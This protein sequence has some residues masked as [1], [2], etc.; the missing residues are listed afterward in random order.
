MDTDQRG[1][2]AIFDEAAEI[3][4]REARSAYLDHAC[5]ADPEL[6]R[7]VELLLRAY[8]EA[9]S[10]MERPAIEVAIGQAPNPPDS[11]LGHAPR[12]IAEGPGTWIGLFK[13]ISQIGE[14]GMGVV[15]MAEQE[16]P[17]RR[18]VALKIIKPGM[19]SA[20]V[21]A[22][23]EAERQALAMMDHPNIARVLDAGTTDSGRPYFVMEL[24]HGVPITRYCD[25][26]HLTPRERLDL[27]LPVCQAIQHAHQKGIIHRDIKPSNVLVTLYDGKPVPKVIDFGV[28][29][30]V[31]QSITERTV[32]TQHGSVVGTLEYMSPEQ[33]EVSPLGVDT[34]SDIYALGVLLY[35]LLTGS[36]PLE[37]ATLREAGYNEI[38]RRIKE[39]EPPRPST[40]LS[41]SRER[42]ASISSQRHTE[43]AR[44]TRLLR[45]ELDW[46][47]MKAL[48]KDRA[49]RYVTANGFARDIERYLA[50]DP[51]EAGPPSATYKLRKLARKHRPAL[52]TIGAFAGLLLLSAAVAIALAIQAVRAEAKA[53]QEAAAAEQAR[54]SE[55][56]LRQTADDEQRRARA[57]EQAA[58]DEQAR[59]KKSEAE[60]R[61]VLEFFRNK[62]LAAGRPKHQEGGLGKSATIRE[63]VDAAVPGIEKSFAGQPTVEASIRD[64]LGQSYLY[65]SEPALAIRHHEHALELRRRALGPDHPDTLTSM[66]SLA[67]AYWAAGRLEDAIRLHKEALE[68]RKATLGPDHADTLESMGSLAVAYQD[69]GRTALALPLFEETLKRQQATLGPEHPDVLT[70]MNNLATA[71]EDAG[72]LAEAVPLFEETLQRRRATLNADHP[73]TLISMSNLARAYREAG[74]LADALPL[75][76]ETLKRQKATLGPDHT[77]TLV[78]MNDL[79]LAYRDLGRVAEAVPLFEE[80][81]RRR[82]ASAG[83]DHPE[84]LK[85]MNNLALAYRDSGR[86]PEAIALYE[87]TLKLAKAKLGPDHNLTLR[88][89]NNLGAAYQAAGRLADALPLFE[90]ALK[91]RQATVGPDHADTLTSI[92]ILARAYL[93][94]KP[95]QAESLLR[96]LLAVRDKQSPDDWQTCEIKSLLGASLLE[97]KRFAEAEPFLVDGYETMKAREPKIQP[98]FRKRLAEAGKRVVT[99][100]TAWGKVD[101]AREWTKKLETAP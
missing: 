62:V 3:D 99:L 68:R 90:A 74:R 49:R 97:Q 38:L 80:A 32:F 15:Y 37:R 78:S 96:Q 24:V 57:A 82:Q 93:H 36:T 20:Q 66:S 11:A 72:Q 45:G 89:M 55:A 69:A 92:S 9:G 95:S 22:R 98:R 54:E 47:V 19:D 58:R 83:P 1:V 23:F 39:E 70:S 87:N 67:T 61:T 100:Y 48:E 46:I 10:F 56:R 86:I 26:T 53:R 40:R 43:P 27:F 85:T 5:A 7:K 30:A 50:G 28:A 51:V 14:G 63:A 84:A 2:K 12:Q 65:L 42:L 17:V 79:A 34:R 13:L 33:A 25:D 29:K 44:L 59:T 88:V 71:Y 52:V 81:L 75:H 77:D 18:K 76:E 91:G 21:I 6:R 35:E 8:T 73:H 41:D 16:R 60:T 101:K 4:D 64:T 94:D 31:D